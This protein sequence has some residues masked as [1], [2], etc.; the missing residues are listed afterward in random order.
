MELT[1]YRSVAEI[2]QVIDGLDGKV[3]YQMGPNDRD[4]KWICN[5]CLC[6]CQVAGGFQN[7]PNLTLSDMLAKSRFLPI[8]SSEKC[9]GRGDCVK[10][11][12]F[13]AITISDGKSQIDAELC[14]GCGSC[15]VNCSSEAIKMKIVRPTS[16]I[17]EGGAQ[18]V[19]VEI[20]EVR[21]V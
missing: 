7:D 10:M 8:V 19:D 14:Y 16:H 1:R 13:G 21:E 18:L 20:L 5:C 17:P 3:H 2:M 4:I 6:H 12:P 9:D 15:V 11:C